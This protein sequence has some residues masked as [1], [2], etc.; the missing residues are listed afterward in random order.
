MVDDAH[1]RV[2][3]APRAAPDLLR[4]TTRVG[5]GAV[6]SL[7]GRAS[8]LLATV[9]RPEPLALPR[10]DGG[11][12]GSS[13]S[14]RPAPVHAPPTAPPAAAPA[15]AGSTPDLV[16]PGS[17]DVRHAVIGAVFDVQDAARRSVTALGSIGARVT[18]TARWLWDAP[19]MGPVR[20]R[21]DERV[22]QLVE[23]G[24][25]EEVT[26]LD[27]SRRA[28]DA[29][30][31]EVTES[32]LVVHVVDEVVGKVIDPVLDATLPLVFERLQ[33]EP[34]A[35]ALIALVN[36]IVGRVLDPILDTALPQVLGR[37]NEEPEVVQELV[38]GQSTSIATEFADSV[39][40]RTVTGDDR[41]EILFGK[42]RR[43]REKAAPGDSA[44]P[45]ED[46]A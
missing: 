45:V 43:R 30:L 13:A 31:A 46:R 10:G 9:E 24:R 6:L 41:V 2:N 21:V 26:S 36:A 7:A 29:T 35:D 5:I 12:G 34:D 4:T 16:L 8:A 23:R 27:A 11:D 19:G 42:R 33:N 37:L 1:I 14:A 15:P 39:R 22:T 44:P 17:D 28:L 32:T 40:A 20:R 18:P 38:R 3:T 25:A